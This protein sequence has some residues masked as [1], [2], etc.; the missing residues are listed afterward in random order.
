MSKYF[1]I[2][3]INSIALKLLS[4]AGITAAAVIPTD[5]ANHLG[6]A[7]K[8]EDL[9]NI[10]GVLIVQNGV[11]TIGVNENH[12]P[13]RQRFTIAHEIGHLVLG[14]ERR[15]MFVD[16]PE[17]EFSMFFRNEDSSEGTKRQEV[18]ANAFAAALLMPEPFVRTEITNFIE[19]NNADKFE[20]SEGKLNLIPE[21]AEKFGVSEMAMTYRIGN[22]NLFNT[23]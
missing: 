18:E 9:G 17:Q 4:A 3:R 13:N 22:L 5:I 12:F 14:H 2:R 6:V 16:Q 11:A 19:K 8:K 7:V 15:G 20:L 10:S 21:M 1:T 23:L